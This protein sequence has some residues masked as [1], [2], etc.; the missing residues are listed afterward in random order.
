MVEDGVLEDIMEVIVIMPNDEMPEDETTDEAVEF[1]LV[2]ELE[3]NE[4][5]DSVD[6]ETLEV[7]EAID[8]AFE[9]G[10]TE[11]DDSLSEENI[12]VMD[13]LEMVEGA[14]LAKTGETE[15]IDDIVAFE[16][17]PRVDEAAELDGM[18]EVTMAT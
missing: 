8:D 4:E 17:A 16:E 11:E 5:S 6:D 9:V 18:A 15:D 14:E 10:K 7:A 3:M 12:V 2:A 1:R 13:P